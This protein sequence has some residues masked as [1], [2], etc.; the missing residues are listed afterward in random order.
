MKILALE[1]YYGGSHRAFLDQWRSHSQH[2]WTVLT[3]PP[4]KWKWRMRHAALTFVR[5]VES[6]LAAGDGWDLVFA[7]DMLDLA[8][9]KGLAPTALHGIPH[10]V[11]FHENQLTYP[12][13]AERE[14]DLH[15]ALTNFST[16]LAADAVWF[17]SSFHREAFL[18]ALPALFRR[19]PDHNPSA[20]IE[21]IRQRCEVH[22]PGILE[23]ISPRG[24]RRPGPV[25]ILWAARWEHDKGP[26]TFFAALRAL[27]AR[28]VEFRLSVI[29]ERFRHCPPDFDAAR[30]RFRDQI[31]HWGYLADRDRYLEA[32]ASADLYV[33]TAHHEFFGISAVEAVAAGA[34][35][36]LPH[37]LSY[38]EV[39]SPLAPLLGD[40]LFYTGGVRPLARKLAELAF[41]V[42]ND[43][44]WPEGN[45]DLG[46]QAMQR[47]GWPTLAP[48]HDAALTRTVDNRQ[49]AHGAVA[50]V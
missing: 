17:N 40:D 32:L 30:E 39:M 11:Y 47:Y 7:S 15:F 37:R 20:E 33:S 4:Y 9:F 13:R 10:I 43:T 42:Q 41:R 35:P 18:G 31:D 49:H 23:P 14:R 3:L 16:A 8:Q 2:L 50:C 48:A 38:P 12:V 44:L 22:P 34:Y 36:V 25:R 24:P 28:Q 21:P 6:K 46:R 5:Q 19:M 26:E 29:G 45:F 27:Q 1:P